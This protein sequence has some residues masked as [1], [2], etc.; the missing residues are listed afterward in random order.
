MPQAHIFHFEMARFGNKCTTPWMV[1]CPGVTMSIHVL[2]GCRFH[3]GRAT[4]RGSAGPL[5][6]ESLGG[7]AG[8]TRGVSTPKRCL[9]RGPVTSSV[10]LRP[11]S[12]LKKHSRK[13]TA[14][15]RLLSAK[16][17]LVAA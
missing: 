7:T 2:Y 16:Q 3:P 9:R 1:V 4:T 12:R 15:K 10:R 8:P 5:H 6:A 11:P 17:G 13:K 14:A